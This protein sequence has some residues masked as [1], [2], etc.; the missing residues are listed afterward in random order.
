[1]GVCFSLSLSAHVASVC[2]RE[3]LL[4]AV[5]ECAQK[6]RKTTLRQIRHCQTEMVKDLNTSELT[7][8]LRDCNKSCLTMV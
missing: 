3:A 8:A 5:D 2:A 1:M 7:A 4:P 6:V